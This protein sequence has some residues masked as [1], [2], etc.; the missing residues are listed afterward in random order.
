MKYNN[1]I[2]F[3]LCIVIFWKIY[4]CNGLLGFKKLIFGK[5][6]VYKNSKFGNRKNIV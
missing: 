3:Y 6:D 4:I 5:N 2:N 1:L